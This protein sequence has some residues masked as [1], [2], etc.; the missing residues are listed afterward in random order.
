M[1]ILGAYSYFT[2]RHRSASPGRSSSREVYPSRCQRKGWLG[3]CKLNY[4][5]D[6]SANCHVDRRNARFGSCKRCRQGRCYWKANLHRFPSY[7]VFGDLERESR[8][9]PYL[10]HVDFSSKSTHLWSMTYEKLFFLNDHWNFRRNFWWKKPWLGLILLTNALLVP[11]LDIRTIGIAFSFYFLYVSR[12]S[13]S[14]SEII[15]IRGGNPSSV[16]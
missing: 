9:T 7:G 10:F 1:R 16:D 11:N 6:S 5:G 12:R 2:L 4:W 14:S 13:R 8:S 3:Q 15:H